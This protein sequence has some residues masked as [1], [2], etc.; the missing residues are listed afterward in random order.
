MPKT[1]KTEIEKAKKTVTTD[2]VQLTIGEIATMYKGGE[3]KINPDFQRL[4]RWE[5]DRKSQFVESILIGIP[6]P[7]IFVYETEDGIWELVDGLQRVSTVLEFMGILRDPDSDETRR[8]VLSPTQ[9]L[10]ALGGRVWEAK[11]DGE[12]A[13]EKPEQLFFRRH[14]IN[15]QV[16]KHPS[17][18]TTKY[19]LFQRLNRGGLVTN[20]QEV[21]TCAMVLVNPKFTQKLR[22]FANREDFREIFRIT[23]LQRSKQKDLEYAVRLLVHSSVDLCTHVNLGKDRDVQVF[24]DEEIKKIIHGKHSD[25]SINRSMEDILWSVSTLYQNL[26]RDALIPDRR[27]G[28]SGRLSQRAL[29]GIVAG[30]ARNR[31]AISQLD[32]PAQYVCDRVWRFWREPK[33]KEMSASGLRGTTRI[34]MSVPFGHRWFSP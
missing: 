7:S 33:V 15:C 17:D 25:K 3:L 29:E 11:C 28:P 21:R 4:F 9:Y 23:K 13:L 26:G 31:K 24:L 12:V 18:P 16:L 30:I 20:E 27:A 19:D 2:S 8:S 10:S 1:L 34:K 5:N 22:D 14:R 6:I 32:D